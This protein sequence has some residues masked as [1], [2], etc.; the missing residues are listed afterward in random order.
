MWEKRAHEKVKPLHHKEWS[1][2]TART[3]NKYKQIGGK[4]ES[5]M[6]GILSF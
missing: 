4:E 1:W 5:A 6:D 3:G 2:P